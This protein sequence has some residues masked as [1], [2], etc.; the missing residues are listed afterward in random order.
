MTTPTII[1]GPAI[2]IYDGRTYYTKG[3]ISEQLARQTFQVQTDQH[4]D[5]D[6]RLQSQ[7]YEINFRPAGQ[8][9]QMDKV[10]PYGPD[11]IGASIFGTSNKA[12]VIHTK[13]GRKIT[14]A[15]AA[16]MKMPVL[17]C[18]PIDTLMGEMGFVVHGQGVVTDAGNFRTLASEA[19]ADASFDETTIKTARYTAAYGASPYDAI[20]AL[21][22]FELEV[23]MGLQV[24][25]A[26]DVGEA[27]IVLSSLMGK[28]RFRPS[29]LTQAQVDTLLMLQDTGALD[30]GESVAKSNTDLVLTSAALNATLHKCGP[31]SANARYALGEHVHGVIEFA[32]KWTFTTGVAN[33]IYTL[34]VQ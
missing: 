9:K 10:W 24:V 34:A 25:N 27:D 26:D 31:V 15:R 23:A 16:M 6:T 11:D 28:C 14:Y 19:F 29:N 17:A 33:D 30:I 13:D 7:R 12:L 2:V 3:G 21:E 1:Q 22:G 18:R 32:S 20:G 8:I 5:I 4:G